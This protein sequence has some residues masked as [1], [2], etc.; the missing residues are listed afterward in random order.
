MDNGTKRSITVVTVLYALAILLFHAYYRIDKC[1]IVQVETLQVS[2]ARFIPVP[3]PASA[4]EGRGKRGA[5]NMIIRYGM[6]YVATVW[7]N[8]MQK[9]G[10]HHMVPYDRWRIM[11]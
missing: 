4:W 11:I 2:G 3:Y 9:K 1:P 6:W 7:R 5:S 8:T 10:G